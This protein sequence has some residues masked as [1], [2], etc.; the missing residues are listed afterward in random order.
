MLF[1]TYGN[2]RAPRL[3]L[4]PGLGVSHEIFLPLVELLREEFYIITVEVDGFILGEHTDFTSIDNQ[5]EQANR[6]INECLGGVIECAYG[7]SMGGKILSR[8][9]ERGEAT[10]THA[11]LDAAPLLSLP[12]WLV[13]PLSSYQSFNV[14]SCYH[15]TGFW[16]WLFRSHYFDA[17]LKEC[18]KV[19][20]FGGR[21]AVI[22]GYKDIYTNKLGAI[23]GANIHYWYG[24]KESFVAKPQVEHLL[25]LHP[26]AQIKVFPAMNHGQLLIDHP[27]EVAKYIG[28]IHE[29]GNY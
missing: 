5:A 25:R 19:Y 16:R 23:R 3:M 29:S 4:L 18:C 6:Y 22:D 2:K 28:N 21:K 9:L 13:A 10:I 11:V 8:M 20:P 15:W 14:W 12:K 17:L 7:L 26:E 27:E 1:H 24:S